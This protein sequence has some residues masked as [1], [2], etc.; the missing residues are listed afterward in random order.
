MVPLFPVIGACGTRLPQ[1]WVDERSV[2]QIKEEDARSQALLRVRKARTPHFDT[3]DDSPKCNAPRQPHP[4]FTAEGGGRKTFAH[5][6][7]TVKWQAHAKRYS[8]RRGRPLHSPRGW[9]AKRAT[10]CA[11]GGLSH[12]HV[13]RIIVL[14]PGPAG[15]CR[16][17]Y[18]G[19]LV[20]SSSLPDL[21]QGKGT[22]VRMDKPERDGAGNRNGG[23]VSGLYNNVYAQP[24]A[25]FWRGRP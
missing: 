12:R 8:L 14:R 4:S 3:I 6:I 24:C 10:G 25:A 15:G 22:G 5:A 17:G 13:M 21:R 7:A 18:V 11:A 23:S 20:L 16:G 19:E 1:P 2:S 9:E